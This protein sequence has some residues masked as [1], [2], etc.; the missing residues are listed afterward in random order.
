MRNVAVCVTGTGFGAARLR[1]RT[2]LVMDP[3]GCVMG[4]GSGTARPREHRASGGSVR[5]RHRNRHRDRFGDANV[6]AWRGSSPFASRELAPTLRG[7]VHPARDGSVRSRHGTATAVAPVT[8]MKVRG[9]DRRRLRHGRRV[10]R[11]EAAQTHPVGNGSMR[12]QLANCPVH[13]SGD[14]N[15]P[16]GRR[17]GSFASWESP[18]PLLP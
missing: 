2:P 7:R 16:G 6:G 13:R 9:E 1:E 8:R 17:I 18:L 4:I 14:A 3:F 10:R 15:V 12:L 5:S 11:R